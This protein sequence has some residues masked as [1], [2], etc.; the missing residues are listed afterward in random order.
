[1]QKLEMSEDQVTAFTPKGDL[2]ALPCGAT[3]IDFAYA[4]HA[5]V[6]DHCV[7]AKING[8]MMPLQTV[9]HS[10]DQVEILTTKFS[11]PSRTWEKFVVTGKAR[12]HVRKFIRTHERAHY[13][14]LG[15]SMVQKTF[16]H[17]QLE[18]S[19]E[20]FETHGAHFKAQTAADFYALIGEGQVSVHEVIQK[21]YPQHSFRKKKEGRDAEPNV[22]YP[23]VPNVSLPLRG[24][25]PGMAAHYAGCCHP[26]PDDRIVGIIGNGPGVTIHTYDCEQ[27]THFISEP[28]RWINVSWDV[29]K[30]GQE[31]SIRLQVVIVNERGA[32][33]NLTSI[34]TANHGDIE[35]LNIADHSF[36]FGKVVI[37]VEVKKVEDIEPLCAALRM[38][39]FIRTVETVER[40]K[41]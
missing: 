19:Q 8:R 6:G 18:W 30:N 26:L 33:A 17:E 2:I 7:G 3:P 34:I 23:K 12:T 21:F 1:M 4:I 5:E 15:R 40:S 31:R 10:G 29:P 20:L 13:I 25:I 27:L 11:R 22:Q 41:R 9:L 32:L 35:E 39:P 37:D 28:D 36:E 14:N 38:C 24:L 16:S